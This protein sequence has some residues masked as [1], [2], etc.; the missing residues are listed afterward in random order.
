MN[1][2]QREQQREALTELL[3]TIKYCLDFDKK[4]SSDWAGVNGGC[5]GYPALILMSSMID[6]M[7][8]YF[9]ECSLT[10]PVDSK[11]ESIEKGS[12]HFLILNQENLFNL[13]L[14]KKTIIDFY[15]TYRSKLVHNSALPPNNFLINDKDSNNIFTL[16]QDLKIRCINIYALFEAIKK[17]TE[18]FLAWLEFGTFSNDHKLTQELLEVAKPP[19][20]DFSKEVQNQA[21]NPSGCSYDPFEQET[22]MYI[23]IKDDDD[24]DNSLY[25]K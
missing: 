16:D 22:G 2:I 23:Q 25:S 24:F 13:G 17:A 1:R 20:Y 19:F 10:I 15:S 12:D 3:V 4:S 14:S 6:T 8:S 11:N 5:L 21:S 18:Q 9:R 7:G